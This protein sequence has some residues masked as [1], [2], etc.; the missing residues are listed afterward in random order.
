MKNPKF[1]S[2][3]ERMKETHD[4][5]NAD[6]ANGTDPYSNFSFASNFSGSSKIQVYLTLIGVKAARLIEL[7]KEGKTP[8]NESINDTLLDFAVYAALMA[9]DLMIEE[10]KDNQEDYLQNPTTCKVCGT[11]YWSNLGCWKCNET[12]QKT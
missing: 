2:L 4:K 5:K 11:K 3:L 10:V 12:N 6:Y 8:K 7:S 9:S 1:I